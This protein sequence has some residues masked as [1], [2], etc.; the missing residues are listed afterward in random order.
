MVVF[1]LPLRPSR[2]PN[3]VFHDFEFDGS[4][5]QSLGFRDRSD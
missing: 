4:L 1:P 5:L 3:T 2:N